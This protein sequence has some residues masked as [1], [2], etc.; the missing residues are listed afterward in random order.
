MRGPP[1]SPPTRLKSNRRG[2]FQSA[3]LFEIIHRV[4]ISIDVEPPE[5]AMPVIRAR[6]SDDIENVRRQSDLIPR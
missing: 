1:T 2:A 3:F 4:E 6:F 5:P